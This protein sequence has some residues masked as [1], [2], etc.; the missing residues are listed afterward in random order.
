MG[1]SCTICLEVLGSNESVV[2]TTCGHVF[3][4]KCLVSWVEKSKTCAQCRAPLT[5]DNFHKLFLEIDD[6]E[7][8][9]K[10]NKNIKFWKKKYHEKEIAISASDQ[11]QN[12]IK[13]KQEK[14]IEKK[15]IVILEL[16]LK[17]EQLNF[18]NQSHSAQIASLEAIID[19]SPFS[20]EQ[21][22]TFDDVRLE[23]HKATYAEALT[24][25]P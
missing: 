1:Y 12:D 17:V 24:K 22:D 13:L 18:T 2:S 3:H 9:A 19:D 15:D 16:E 7:E 23:A 21:K 8:L 5:S 4:E 6:E 14:I 20:K 11:I 25:K 10:A